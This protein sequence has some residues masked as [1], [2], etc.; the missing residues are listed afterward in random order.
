MRIS[1][2]STE[3]KT[4]A[5]LAIAPGRKGR[6]LDEDYRRWVARSPANA[7]VA[8]SV[9]VT[10]DPPPPMTREQRIRAAVELIRTGGPER[11]RFTRDGK[12]FVREVE[13]V[14]GVHVSAAER[15]AA[16]SK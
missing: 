14:S 16:W 10:A 3:V 1:N 13:R 7:A 2:T 5:G 12:P 11:Y 15:D 8:A 6:V 9:T 4:V